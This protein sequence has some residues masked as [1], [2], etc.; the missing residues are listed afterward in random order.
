MKASRWIDDKG[1][2][3]ELTL[4]DGVTFHNGDPLTSAD[5]R[6]SFFERPKS[7]NTLMVSGVFGSKVADIE[8]PSPTTAIFRFNSPYVVGLALLGSLLSY[9]LAAIP[10]AA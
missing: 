3:L 2:A 4:R 7:D 6:F 9:V 10:L 5:I 8:T 1:M